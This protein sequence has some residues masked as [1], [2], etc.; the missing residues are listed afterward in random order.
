MQESKGA[1]SKALIGATPISVNAK[2]IGS[3]KEKYKDSLAV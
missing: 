1:L 2:H 3:V